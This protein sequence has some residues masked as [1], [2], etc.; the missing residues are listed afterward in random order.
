MKN[1]RL[2]G[3]ICL[4]AA[5]LSGVYLLGPGIWLLLA[6]TALNVFSQI[7]EPQH[8]DAPEMVVFGAGLSSSGL[9]IT[10]GFLVVGFRRIAGK[11]YPGWRSCVTFLLLS[12]LLV[13]S[14]LFKAHAMTDPRP[15][16]PGYAGLEGVWHP[17]GDT[18][19]TYRFNLDGS[20]ESSWGGL[21][22]SKF[23]AWTRT[24]T[25][26]TAVTDRDWTFT[27]TLSGSS[28]KGT[29]SISSSKKVLGPEEW[30]RDVKP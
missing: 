2:S 20:L 24:G 29:M 4:V 8:S 30:V 9:C 19:S 21:P 12:L 10:V 17:A 22:F 6:G 3:P 23:G 14:A 26:I 25:T 5:A 27:G 13:V 18:K 11:P 1:L 28:I 15:I 7:A 16:P